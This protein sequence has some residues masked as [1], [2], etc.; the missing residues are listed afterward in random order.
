[1]KKLL[2]AA[3]LT[4]SVCSFGANINATGFESE[5]DWVDSYFNKGTSDASEV[6]SYEEGAAPAATKAMAAGADSIGSK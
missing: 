6:K 2:I 4:A 3:A 1:M 5:G